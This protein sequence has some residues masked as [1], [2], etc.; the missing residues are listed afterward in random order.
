MKVCSDEVPLKKNLEKI[1][2][3][4]YDEITLKGDFKQEKTFF[5]LF[6]NIFSGKETYGSQKNEIEIG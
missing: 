5:K 6:R 3:L 2:F 4:F 1:L